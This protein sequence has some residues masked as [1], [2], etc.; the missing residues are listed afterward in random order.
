MITVIVRFNSESFTRSYSNNATIADVLGDTELKM[1][2]GWG[3][4]VRALI[5]GVEQ[6][7]ASIL[8]EGE[9]V[10]IE[11]RSNSKATAKS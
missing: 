10:V 6:S 7:T 9:T 8:P 2:A 4:S 1:A 5:A 11:T 3:D